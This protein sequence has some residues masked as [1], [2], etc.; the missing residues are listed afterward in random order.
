MD[1]R[2]LKDYCDKE[3]FANKDN[4]CLALDSAY[5]GECPFRRTDITMQD[6]IDQMIRY[7]PRRGLWQN[8]KN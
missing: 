4:R 7:D 1:E 6:Q 8:L 5:R 3:C 2:Y